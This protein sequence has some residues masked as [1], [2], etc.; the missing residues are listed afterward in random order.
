MN[1][2]RTIGWCWR[3]RAGNEHSVRFD[4]ADLSDETFRIARESAVR[5]GYPG[6]SGGFW[7]YLQDDIR[8]LFGKPTQGDFHGGAA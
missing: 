5:L 1:V 4:I 2:E 8:K 3:D 7:N 6:H